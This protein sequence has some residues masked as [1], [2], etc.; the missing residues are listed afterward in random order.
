[1]QAA[2][3][4][5]E[6]LTDLDQALQMEEDQKEAG[7]LDHTV[8][9]AAAPLAEE[10]VTSQVQVDTSRMMEVRGVGDE[11]VIAGEV[12]GMLSLLGVAGVRDGVEVEVVEAGVEVE[13]WE[14]LWIQGSG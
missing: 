14:W 5:L 11:E 2:A 13:G 7:D 8:L 1:V 3:E 6:A 4:D 12:E 9:E 10:G